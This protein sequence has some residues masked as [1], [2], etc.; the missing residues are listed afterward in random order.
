MKWSWL[1]AVLLSLPFASDLLAQGFMTSDVA[2]R[3][4]L[5]FVS[6]PCLQTGG[7]SKSLPSNSRVFNHIVS[8]DNHCAEQITVRI[9]YHRSDACTV[10]NVPGGS[11]REQIIGAFPAM[12]TFQYDVREQF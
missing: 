9:C 12:Q 6:K 1:F 7:S 5:D 3:R 11:H 10:V 2:D 4:H 8:L